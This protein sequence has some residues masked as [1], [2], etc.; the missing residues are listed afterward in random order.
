M[1]TLRS[2]SARR[3][4]IE[5]RL[6]SP[7]ADEF[8]QRL[9][10]RRFLPLAAREER[11]YGWVGADNLLLTEFDVDTVIRGEHAVLG[12]R[13]DRRRVNPRLLR[14]RLDLE[15]QARRKAAADAGQ[16]LRLSRDERQQL[17]VDLHQEL[18]RDTN[19]SVEAHT[20]VLHTKRRVLLSLSLTRRV[21]E[22]LTVLFRDTFGAELVPLTPWRRGGEI[23][24]G[25]SEGD[26]SRVAALDGLARTDFGVAPASPLAAP[27]ITAVEAPDREAIR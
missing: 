22:V 17:K 13:I 6:P 8:F 3:Y 15:I 27:R 23:L 24:A 16:P 7:Y 5:G 2:T 18:L 20:V 10:D 14:A 4:R 19:P 9:R 11:T 25:S 1:L 12:L 21:H 26:T